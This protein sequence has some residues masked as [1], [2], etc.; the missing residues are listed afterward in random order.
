MTARQRRELW[1][2]RIG[3]IVTSI[4]TVLEFLL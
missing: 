4:L 2:W 3:G 1:I